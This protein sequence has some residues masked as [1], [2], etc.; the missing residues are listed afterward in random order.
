MKNTIFHSKTIDGWANKYR[1]H[2]QATRVYSVSFLTSNKKS[3]PLRSFLYGS[4]LFSLLIFFS[5]PS[6]NSAIRC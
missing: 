2:W 1:A 3:Y 5:P 6:S 4:Y